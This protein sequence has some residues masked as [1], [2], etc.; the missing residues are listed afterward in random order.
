MNFSAADIADSLPLARVRRRRAPWLRARDFLALVAAFFAT[1]LVCGSVSA[2][3]FPFA[4]N[5]TANDLPGL[6]R[7][8]DAIA[9][10][11]A[12][13]QAVLAEVRRGVERLSRTCT[14]PPAPAASAPG[15]EA[16]LLQPQRE[17]SELRARLVDKNNRLSD[18][19][20]VA[21]GARCT[22]LSFIPGIKSPE[23]RTAEALRDASTNVQKTLAS[24]FDAIDSRYRLYI[25]VRELEDRGCA[26]PGFT[27]RLIQ[28]DDASM[29]PQEAAAQAAFEEF[30]R[31]AEQA[32][33]TLR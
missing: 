31:A 23:C 10:A 30:L 12:R 28:A 15:R 5:T 19:A 11:D 1:F 22:G 16:F 7:P 9:R 8:L 29:R 2:Q 18:V 27:Q 17:A 20:R 21:A 4:T 13:E 25:D 6:R 14:A 32:A 33:A 26:R 3:A 24:Y